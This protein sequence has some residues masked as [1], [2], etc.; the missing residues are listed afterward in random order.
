MM[1][2]KTKEQVYYSSAVSAMLSITGRSKIKQ[3]DQRSKKQGNKEI[4]VKQGRSPMPADILVN[5]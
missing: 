2:H 3:W 5:I 4:A 1:G